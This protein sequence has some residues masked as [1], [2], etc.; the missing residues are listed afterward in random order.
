MGSGK[1]TL[2]KKLAKE[3]DFTFIDT[4]KAIAKQHGAI[5][6]IF[7]TK[8]EEFFRDLESR[9]LEDALKDNAIVATGGGA[10]L[11]EA[12]RYLLRGHHVVFLDTS[13]EHVL[14]KINLAK[15]PLL[16]ENPERW[17]QIYDE[18]ISIYR[19]VADQTVFSGGKG[20]R[21]LLDEIKEGLPK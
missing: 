7:E 14:G 11:R 13:A 3:L 2:G 9:A 20:I 19:Q 21:S 15:R 8:G 4:D 6:R 18:R 17:Q 12:N 5:N 10:I 1:T 16:K